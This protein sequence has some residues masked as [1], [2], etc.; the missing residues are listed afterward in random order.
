MSSAQRVAA[1][2]Q[3][4]RFYTRTIGVLGDRLQTT[5]YSLTEARVIYELSQG[6]QMETVEL[7][8]RLGLDPGYL[9]RIFT[10]FEAD[11]V[12]RL[13][14]S[15]ADSRRQTV[16][17]TES[18]RRVFATLDQHAGL[19]M[20]ALLDRL[21][22]SDQMRLLTAMSTIERLLYTPAPGAQVTLRPPVAGDMGW[23]AH[24]QGV[25]YAE[26][27]GYDH[28]FEALVGRIVADYVENHVPGLEDAWIAEV[29][30]VPAGSIFCVRKDETTAQ[31]R[32]LFVEPWARGLGVGGKLVRQCLRFAIDAGYRDMVL[33]TNKD[34]DAARRIYERA[35][36]QLISEEQEER[37]GGMQTF[38]NWQVRLSEATV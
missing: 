5:P 20:A 16:Q 24:R 15:Q 22:D 1:V 38:Q 36:F 17:L 26:E 2:R 27:Y 6:E 33:W 34:L 13:G 29:D 32:L 3:F 25:V 35:G 11:G 21:G 10:R 7:R 4:N 18:G 23:V 28:Y 37:F 19:E 9:S 31:L 12:V 14:R 8:N 30:G